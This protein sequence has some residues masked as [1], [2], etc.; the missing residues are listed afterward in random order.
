MKMIPQAIISRPRWRPSAI[1]RLR[2]PNMM[3]SAAAIIVIASA[4]E[5][6]VPNMWSFTAS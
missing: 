5:A 2:I 4:V 6:I 3:S 1:F